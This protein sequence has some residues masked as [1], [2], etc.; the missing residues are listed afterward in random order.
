MISPDPQKMLRDFLAN[1]ELRGLSP[2]SIKTYRNYLLTF[3]SQDPPIVNQ[4]QYLRF[5]TSRY[6]NDRTRKSAHMHLVVF[7]K[8]AVGERLISDWVNG[9]KLRTRKAPFPPTLTI[10]EFQNILDVMPRNYVGLR[11]KALFG[12]L[13][14]IGCRRDAVRTLKPEDVNLAERWIRTTSKGKERFKTLPEPAVALLRDWMAKRL[15]SPWLFPSVRFPQ[16]CINASAIT[17]Y[18]PCYAKAAGITKRVHV[19]LL[20]HSHAMILADS[21]VPAEVIQQS[22]DHS[23]IST[24]LIY[25]HVS[26]KRVRQTLDNVFGGAPE[27]AEPVVAMAMAPVRSIPPVITIPRRLHPPK[28]ALDDEDWL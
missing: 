16:L 6:P 9:F 1:R 15:D 22:L 13:F 4:I 11:D 25:C 12:T 10:A 2:W 8:W 23:D 27:E 24:T 14:F 18:L 7:L 3:L 5:L 21:G 17:H 28:V 19:H 26:Q 20:R